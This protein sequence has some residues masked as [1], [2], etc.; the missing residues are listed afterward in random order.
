MYRII[1]YQ[2]KNC[3][4]L[5]ES[6]SDCS[7]HERGCLPLEV[8]QLVSFPL[9]HLSTYEGRITEVHKAVSLGAKVS[10]A[11]V[12]IETDEEIDG[13]ADWSQLHDGKHFIAMWD[14]VTLV[15]TWSEV[16]STSNDDN[17]YCPYFHG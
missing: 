11:F 12:C 10:K 6:T 3:E 9:H 5:F 14:E 1:Y 17:S 4:G 16:P 2:C 13:Q 15:E 8:G 7:E